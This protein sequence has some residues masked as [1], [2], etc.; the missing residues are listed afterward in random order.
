MDLEKDEI[1]PENSTVNSEI[2]QDNYSNQLAEAEKILD[3]NTD[4]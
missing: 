2:N 1:M 4:L 3:K